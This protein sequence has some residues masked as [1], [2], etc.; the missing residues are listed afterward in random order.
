MYHEM[1]FYFIIRE[2][3]KKKRTGEAEINSQGE[4][5]KVEHGTPSILVPGKG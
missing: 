5:Y 4:K 1:P 3:V 2:S